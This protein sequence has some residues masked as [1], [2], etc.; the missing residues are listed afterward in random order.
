MHIFKRIYNDDKALE[1]IENEQEKFR[2]K[3]SY[4]RQENPKNISQE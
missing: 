2:E 1:D 3:L 4:I